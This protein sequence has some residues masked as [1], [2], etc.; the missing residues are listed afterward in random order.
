M[1]GDQRRRALWT[2]ADQALSSLTNAA[3]AIVV[4]RSVDATTFG[5]FSLALITYG[6]LVGFARSF[7]GEPYIVAAAALDESA[8]RAGMRAATG[9]ALALGVGSGL[10]CS[11]VALVLHGSGGSALL[12]MG[13]SLPGLLLQ[14]TW[15]LIFFAIQRPAQACLNDLIWTVVQV[16]LLW[17]VLANHSTHDDVF[18]ITLAWGAS[19]LVAAL[20]GV[21]QV[22][23]LPRVRGAWA[24]LRS[25]RELNTP[26]ALGYVINMGSI[27]VAQWAVG[28]VSGLPAVAALRAA[29]TLLGPIN[30]IFSAFNS[31]ALPM[32]ARRHA[33][34]RRLRFLSFAG[35]SGLGAVALVWV[36]IM[37]LMPNGIG[38]QLLGANW[39][40]ADAVMLPSG[41]V[42]L[43]GALVLG[44]SNALI[45]MNRADLS[46]RITLVQA[47]LFLILG[48]YGARLDGAVG[49]SW[50]FAIAQSTGLVLA[51]WA[52]LAVVPKPRHRQ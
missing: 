35:S 52:F 9:G 30:L 13:L 42:L 39:P 7:I 19:A 16:A 44:A 31:Y 10:V 8:R 28:F 1:T 50:G 37:L 25:Y 11:L 27:Q 40:G 3:L 46:L 5:A 2:F 34:G 49:A 4:A 48:L 20:W 6:F 18:L 51:W 15:R 24:W 38:R 12:A 41:I 36:S 45:A 22:R 29:Q 17:L 26:L 33:A 47:P 14:D 32:F 43:A 23:T 21:W